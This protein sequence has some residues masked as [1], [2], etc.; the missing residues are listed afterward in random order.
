MSAMKENPSFIFF[1]ER[2]GG[3]IREGTWRLS[4]VSYSRP[5]FLI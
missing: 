4:L 3:V 5:L 2:K 1:V